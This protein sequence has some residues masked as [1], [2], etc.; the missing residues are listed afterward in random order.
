MDKGWGC[1]GA[2]TRCRP[3]TP[4]NEIARYA[5]AFESFA[6]DN[7]EL[8]FFLTR[9]GCG[10]AGYADRQIAPLLLN[11]SQNVLRPPEWGR[12]LRQTGT[13]IPTG[14]DRDRAHTRGRSPV[15]RLGLGASAV[16]CLHDNNTNQPI[17]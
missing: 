17:K 15:H 11:A 4:L 1:R 2:L 9:L 14:S 8:L 16:P 12:G 3:W 10:L 5:E 13:M 6:S 7:P